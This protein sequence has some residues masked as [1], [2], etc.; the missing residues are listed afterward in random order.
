MPTPNDILNLSSGAQWLKADLHVHTPASV[1]MHENWKTAT[2]A[3]VV[4]IAIDKGLDAIAITD[5]NT[6]AWCD[7]VCDA[8]IGTD[9]TV[10]PGVEISTHQGHVLAI[11]DG[12][13]NASQIEDLL[14]DVGIPRNDF[15]SLNVATAQ[16]IVEVS[17]AI[18]SVG[19][20]AV[21][22]HADSKRRLLGDDQRWCG[23]STSLR[24]PKIVG[25]GNIGYY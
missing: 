15:G 3:D 22:A 14:I 12:S 18:A 2:A 8:A 13:V 24:C 19:G 9:L 23:T 7:A 17:S 4:K 1:D 6:A 25:Y 10:F 20:V 21:A 11:F 16:G 5:H